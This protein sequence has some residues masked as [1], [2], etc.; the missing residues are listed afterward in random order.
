MNSPEEVQEVT[1]QMCG[2]S[3]I[4]EGTGK[5]GFTCKCV[6]IVEELDIE[7]QLYVSVSL[8]RKMGMPCITYSDMGG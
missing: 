8:N 5:I 2:R 4:C 1:G 6:Y 7:K 3:L